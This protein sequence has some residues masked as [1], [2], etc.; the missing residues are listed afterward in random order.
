MRVDFDPA[1]EYISQVEAR[2][3]MAREYRK[4][5]KLVV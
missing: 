4:P 2:K 3:Y 1:R 5:W